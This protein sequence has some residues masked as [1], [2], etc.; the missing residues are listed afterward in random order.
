MPDTAE[1]FVGRTCRHIIPFLPWVCRGALID[2]SALE[3]LGARVWGYPGCLISTGQSHKQDISGMWRKGNHC[4]CGA[5][6]CVCVCVRACTHMWRL[7][8]IWC[9]QLHWHVTFCTSW[10]CSFLTPP[11][12]FL[13]ADTQVKVKGSSNLYFQQLRCLSWNYCSL[14]LSPPWI[15]FCSSDDLPW[16][17]IS[18]SA[19]LFFLLTVQN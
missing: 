14:T 7:Q 6:L 5:C 17:L 10:I 19:I 11:L 1:I 13:Q 9:L 2:E 4:A 18:L 8:R 16:L 3:E 12:V 15:S